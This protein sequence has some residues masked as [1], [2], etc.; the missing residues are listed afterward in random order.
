[1]MYKSKNVVKLL[2][3]STLLAICSFLSV[4]VNAQKII[5]PEHPGIKDSVPEY[6]V[7][8][9]RNRPDSVSRLTLSLYPL[10]A[11]TWLNNLIGIPLSLDVSYDLNKKLNLTGIV[12]IGPN[13]EYYYGNGPVIPKLYYDIEI[14]ATYYFKKN[15]INDS[16]KVWIYSSPGTSVIIKYKGN[17]FVKLGFRTSIG[18]I[19]TTVNEYMGYDSYYQINFIGYDIK[20]PSMKKINFKSDP[21][22]TYYRENAYTSYTNLQMAYV[23]IGLVYEK[24]KDELLKINGLNKR[25]KSRKYQ[26]YVDLLIAP[27]VTY[28]N[29]VLS[30]VAS[31]GIDSLPQR[32]IN[33]DKFTPKE[34]L[35]FKIGWMFESLRKFGGTTNIELGYLPNFG[36]FLNVKLGLSCN[37]KKHWNEAK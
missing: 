9:L 20:D 2:V 22:L 12:T 26:L 10:T 17:H 37:P 27:F 15:I 19:N 35:G 21:S 33:V 18:V 32:T 7:D 29:I 4:N 13:I 30:R 3:I 5:Y 23:Q 25:E 16:E 1:M 6:A 8:I 28:D 24:V 14:G 34:L 36:A 11:F 31:I